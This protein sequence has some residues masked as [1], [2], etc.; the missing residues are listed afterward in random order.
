MIFVAVGCENQAK[1][2]DLP[3]KQVAPEGGNADKRPRSS[4]PAAPKGD[5]T[6][7]SKGG[8]GTK[9]GASGSS[10][11][12]RKAIPDSGASNR[13][14]GTDPSGSDDG[15]W[16]GSRAR[17]A[18]AGKESSTGP[19]PGG[20]SKAAASTRPPKPRKAG[21]DGMAKPRPITD[22]STGTAWS[23]VLGT[24]TGPDHADAAR[25]ANVKLGERI[26]ALA[27]GVV[28]STSQGSM[29]LWGQFVGLEDPNGQREL[30][31][32]QA[33][34][35]RGARPFATAMLIRPETTRK[36]PTGPNDLRHLR[37][38]FPSIDP[39]YTLQVAAWADFDDSRPLEEIR[40][41]AE[42]YA[43]ELRARGFDA[44]YN[45]DDDLKMS[46]VTVGAFDRTAYDPQ[47]T[48]FSPELEQLIK[49]F[50]EHLVNGDPLMLR[51]D[52]R[53]PKSAEVPQACPLVEVPR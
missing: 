41:R 8:S 16:G 15:S 42:A 50:P 3:P 28:R 33:L 19:R 26:P 6:A 14:S 37:A 45:H 10:S 52:P 13:P 43:M 11:G 34:E 38:K 32:I 35:Y 46:V 39:L 44:W 48:L 2:V 20:A 40:R 29:I 30:K 1:P 49:Q 47:S 18:T 51:I 23:I 21:L 24:F 9:K 25:D 22:A 12:S 4:Q 5:G 27:G 31:R 36:P 53:N 17:S 7:A